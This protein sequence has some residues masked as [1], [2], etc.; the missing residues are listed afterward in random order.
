MVSPKI[1]FDN[2]NEQSETKPDTSEI[3]GVRDI[4]TRKELAETPPIGGRAKKFNEAFVDIAGR[5]V[6]AGFNEEELSYVFKCAPTTI[7]T[8]K[9]HYPTFKAA[10]ENGKRI[11]KRK[12]IASAIREAMGYQFETTKKH[13]VRDAD[14]KTIKEDETVFTNRT[15]SNPQLIMFV[16]CNLARQL[17]DNDWA[18]KHT[19]EMSD[20]GI[21]I[22]I[23]GKLESDRI[24]QLAG[25][26]L[27]E[28]EQTTKFVESKEINLKNVIENEKEQINR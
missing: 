23:E 15:P 12:L 28:A 24:A 4:T 19:M 16:L 1:K 27:K 10:C 8:W 3:Q 14:G 25:K 18:S 7:K 17:G 2:T 21:R 11:I 6:A 26:L 9:Q 20:G 13:I 22:K 5:L